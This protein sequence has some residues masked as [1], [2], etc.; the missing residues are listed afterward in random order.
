MEHFYPQQTLAQP[1]KC[2]GIG[3]HSGKQTSIIIHPAPEN[4]GIRFRR[5]DLPGTPDIQALFKTVVDTS[6]ATVIGKDGVIISTIE[7][8]MAAFSGLSIDNA[9]VEIDGYEM[10]IMDGSSK[11]FTQALTRVGMK[12]Q[13][14]PRWFFV[15]TKPV[16]FSENDKFVEI[17]PG[18]GFSI[19]CTIEFDHPLIGRQKISFDPFKESFKDKISHARTFGFIQDLE[20]LKRFSLG[21]GGSLDT[22]V[23][24]DKDRILNKEGLRYPDEFVR[25]KLLDSIGDFSLLGMPIQGHVTTFKSGHAMNHAFIKHLLLTRDSWETRTISPEDDKFL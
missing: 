8:L 10:P 12:Q 22:A 13:A 14:A 11:E 9:L 7:H 21:R 25:H 2:S 19:S 4:H 6:L 24:I 18:K 1:V 3:V 17:I 23:V 16:R 20:Y 5:V 15:M